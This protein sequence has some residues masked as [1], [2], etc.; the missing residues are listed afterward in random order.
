[1]PPSMNM[2]NKPLA[3]SLINLNLGLLAVSLPPLAWAQAPAPT[4]AAA[5]ESASSSRF[6]DKP[7]PL[8]KEGFPERPPP[9]IEWGDRFLGPGNLQRGFTLPTGANWTPSLWVYGDFRTAVQTFD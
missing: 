9:L 4:P 2:I 6:S 1:M 3:R 7:A 5:Q 8:M